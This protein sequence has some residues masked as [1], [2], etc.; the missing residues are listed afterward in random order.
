MAG[1]GGEAYRLAVL[2]KTPENG[3]A[4]D[5]LSLRASAYP[6]P[7]KGQRF[8][9]CRDGA[10]KAPVESLEELRELLREREPVLQ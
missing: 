8:Y 9:L 6:I 10:C 4:L 2:A 5:G 7:E 1:G 3:R